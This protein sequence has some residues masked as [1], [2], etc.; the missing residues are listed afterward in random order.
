MKSA[1][2]LELKAHYDKIIVGLLK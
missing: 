1:V 2:K